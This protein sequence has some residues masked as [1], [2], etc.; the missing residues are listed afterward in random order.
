MKI[1]S[2]QKEMLKSVPTKEFEGIAEVMEKRYPVKV[3]AY[4][5]G[6]NQFMLHKTAPDK[7]GFMTNYITRC[8]VR[9]SEIPNF[10]NREYE[11]IEY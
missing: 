6:D 7:V 8:A 11:E 2:Q 9:L 3:R 10:D 4:K 1:T 5:V